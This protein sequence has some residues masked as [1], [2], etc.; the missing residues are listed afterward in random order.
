MVGLVFARPASRLAK[1]EIIPQID[2]WHY[3][4][5]KH[6]DFFFAGYTYPHP[7]VNGYV[8]VPISGEMSWLYS[9]ERFNAFRLDIEN[10]TKW[11]YRGGSELLLI[12]SRPNESKGCAD[13]DFSTTVSCQLDNM[14]E[15]KAF[16]SIE[17]FFEAIFRFAETA[18]GKDPTWGFSGCQRIRVGR[19]AL[20]N[21]IL[22]LI[23]SEIA[24]G[25]KRA[26][27]FAVRNVGA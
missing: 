7:P 2:D 3:R 24:A 5:G 15:D 18:D 27:H 4:S 21:V 17:Q 9:A 20:K 13:F 16:R 26:E 11:R 22:S 23:H 25:Y 19:E 1:S 10:R 6:I 14:K 8:E 12:N